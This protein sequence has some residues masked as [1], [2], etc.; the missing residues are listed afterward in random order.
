MQKK[1]RKFVDLSQ[2]IKNQAMEPQVNK[3]EYHVHDETYRE[4]AKKWKLAA[5]VFPTPGLFIASETITV[6]S[7]SGTHMDAPWHYGPS[8]EGKPAKTIDEIPLEWCFNDGVVLDFS[9]HSPADLVMAK[10]IEQKLKE[11]NYELKPLDIVMIRTDAD[12]H[13]EE[14]DFDQ[15]HCGLSREAVF[16]LTDR[17]VK[18]VGIDGWGVDSPTDVMVSEVRKGN[19]DRFYPAH[20]A[21]RDVEYLHVEKM[22]N[23]DQLPPFGFTVAVFPIN[24]YRAS[25]G[26]VRAVAIIEE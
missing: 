25:G 22:G 21:G 18:I 17:G 2:P 9:N 14:H 8:C 1:K 7:H 15:R 10:D 26:W 3:I 6:S 23:L 12:K 16:Y 24:I 13:T 20:M 19:K 11:I 5:D 4:R